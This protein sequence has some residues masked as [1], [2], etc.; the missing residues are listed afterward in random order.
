MLLIPFQGSWGVTNSA[1]TINIAN[2]GY[3]VNAGNQRNVFA[4]NYHEG[5]ASKGQGG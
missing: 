4:R 1:E 5:A 2:Q 3:R